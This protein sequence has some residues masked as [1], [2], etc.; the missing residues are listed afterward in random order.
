MPTPLLRVTIYDPGTFDKRSSA[1]AYASKC[2]QT[3]LMDWPRQRN[4]HGGRPSSD[5]TRAAL[6]TNLSGNGISHRDQTPGRRS[7]TMIPVIT[8]MVVTALL[9]AEIGWLCRC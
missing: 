6:Q 4:D 2:L 5:R 3:A 1:A 8:L 7:A 9:A